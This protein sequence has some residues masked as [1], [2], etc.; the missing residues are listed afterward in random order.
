LLGLGFGAGDE[1]GLGLES[2]AIDLGM[3]EGVATDWGGIG[4]GCGG[5]CGGAGGTPMASAVIITN[6]K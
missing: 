2:I 6:N 4:G 3:V 5:D 1:E